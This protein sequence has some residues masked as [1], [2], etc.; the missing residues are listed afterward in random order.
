MA[1]DHRRPGEGPARQNRRGHDGLQ[2]GA[3]RNRRRRRSRDRL[4]AQEGPRRRRQEVRPHRRRGPGRRRL[5]PEQGGDG[6]GQRRDRLRRAQRDFPGFRREV[7]KIALQVGD[8]LDA[9]KAAPF[10]GTGRTVADELTHL[11]A[12]IGEN[13]TIR[14]AKVLTRAAGRRRQLH[15]PGAEAGPGQDRRAR[16][17][18]GP[19]RT[20]DAGNPR[21]PDRH[22]CRRHPARMRWIS[23]PST[24]EALERESAVLTEQASASGRP[25]AIIAKMVEGRIRKF[26]EEVVLLEQVWV[27]DGESRV[28]AVVKKAGVDAHRLR[29]LRAGRG[30]REAE[31]R[32][33]RRGRRHRRRLNPDRCRISSQAAPHVRHDRRRAEGSAARRTSGAR[34]RSVTQGGPQN[35]HDR[36]G[37]VK[38]GRRRWHIPDA[39]VDPLQHHAGVDAQHN[40][41][42]RFRRD[43]FLRQ[44]LVSKLVI[45]PAR[46]HRTAAHQQ[47]AA[48]ARSRGTTPGHAGR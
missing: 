15:A 10:P 43:L 35:G 48:S 23:T 17:R 18:R 8:D 30:H 9:I 12:T 6:R 22:A 16:R 1:D 19:R 37:S 5:G 34:L 40:G 45:R 21:P 42:E 46:Q 47:A 26:Y 3:D 33:R 32:F 39:P 27:H 44:I 31:G 13:M 11:V 7:A 25:E 24:P 2:E 20:R 29:A 38:S 28:R 36:A 41:V 4:A 14:R